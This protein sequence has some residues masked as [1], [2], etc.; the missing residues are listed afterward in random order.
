MANSQRYRSV[1]YIQERV[2]QAR[3]LITQ[4]GI[5][6]GIALPG[7][8]PS[9]GSPIVYDLDQIYRPGATMNMQAGITGTTVTLS[10]VDPSLP[11]AVFVHGRWEQL[12]G[13]DFSSVVFSGSGDKYIYLN[14]VLRIVTSAEDTSLVDSGGSPTANMGEIDFVIGNT[15]TSGTSLDIAL[16]LEKNTT[17]IVLFKFNIASGICTQVVLDNVNTPALGTLGISGLVSTTTGTSNGIVPG[18]DDSRMSDARN[19]LPLSVTD[20]AVRVPVPVSGTN[21]WDLSNQYNLT[22]DAGGISADKIIYTEK[23]ERLSDYLAYLYAQILDAESGVISFNTRT[24]AVVPASGDYSYSMVGAAPASHVGTPLGL[25]SSHQAL[26]STDT[27][28]FSVVQDSS[29]P[30]T[31]GGADVE[32]STTAN[33][34]FGLF[35]N[36]GLLSG[37]LHNGDLMCGLLNA[38]VAAPHVTAPVVVPSGY[39]APTLNYTG[40]LKGLHDVAQVVVDHVNQTTDCNPHGLSLNDLGG[41]AVTYSFGTNGY[42]KLDMGA[43]NTFMI[44]WGSVVVTQ[45][46]A[47]GQNINF[48]P[49]F[50]HACLGVWPHARCAEGLD[51]AYAVVSVDPTA[52]GFSCYISGPSSRST[53]WL[54]IGN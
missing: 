12:F 7:G 30:S 52:A 13:T 49:E 25:P 41:A 17:P 37:I 16:Y 33:A 6:G 26:V 27:G 19:P 10:A 48:S 14:Y 47:P 18:T 29:G 39:V 22:D 23:T 5:S 2:L 42:I 11:M 36:S 28:G 8:A 15:D 50:P 24:G 44:Q 38:L 31:G 32:G 21:A 9:V 3:E 43:G 45:N 1:D 40:A 54:A 34:A 51:A 35:T 46:S 53:F 4:Q 20:A